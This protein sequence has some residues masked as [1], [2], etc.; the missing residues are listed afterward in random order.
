[1]TSHGQV[2]DT[3]ARASM[4]ERVATWSLRRRFA[5]IAVM[6]LVASTG[7]GG[8]AMYWA[9][10]AENDQVRDARLEQSAVTLL[11]FA[12]SVRNPGSFNDPTIALHLNMRPAAALSYR[13]QVWS[14][15]GALLLRAPGASASRPLTALSHRGFATVRIDDED[16]RVFA[17][18][19]DDGALV[20]QLAESISGRWIDIARRISRDMC[21]LL[22]SYGLVSVLAWLMLRRAVRAIEATAHQLEH[23]NPL[24]LAALRIDN[25]PKELLP[26]L[27]AIDVL[28]ARVGL[29][30]SSERHFT[31][32]AAHEMRTPLAGLRAHAQLASTARDGT[33]LQEALQAVRSGVD[34]VSHLIDQLLD[35]ARLDALPSGSAPRLERVNVADVYQAAMVDMEFRAPGKQTRVN[36]RLDA[37]EIHGHRAALSMLLRNLLANAILYSPA[38]A[39]V[40]VCCTA[41]EGGVALTVDDAGPGIRQADRQNAFERFNRLGLSRVDGVGLGLSIVL[42]VVELHRARIQLLDSPLGGLRVQV[43]FPNA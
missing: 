15:E 8:V 35:L 17:V 43:D 31:A 37:E 19:T 2:V 11:H 38:G 7:I 12:E 40:E 33:E 42:S 39:V 41:H 23:R 13:Y 4:S 1:M 26:T 16:S 20:V 3:T 9:E 34:R 29:A 5:L 10:V 32:V 18:P 6:V 30:L 14:R 27:T 36:A 21:Y 24:D 25:P 22:I 28:F